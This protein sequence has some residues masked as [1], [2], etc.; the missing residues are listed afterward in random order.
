MVAGAVWRRLWV[1]AW[2]SPPSCESLEPERYLITPIPTTRRRARM[3]GYNQARLFAETIAERVDMLLIDALERR[4][5]GSTQ[6]GLHP[7]ER[8]ANVK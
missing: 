1:S 6:V 8:R 7:A 5:H 4:C 2:P 3:H